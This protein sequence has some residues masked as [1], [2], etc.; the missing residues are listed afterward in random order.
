MPSF[1]AKQVSKMGNFATPLHEDLP[2]LIEWSPFELCI[3][4]S[5]VDPG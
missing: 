5:L 4:E 3:S 1:S 2:K